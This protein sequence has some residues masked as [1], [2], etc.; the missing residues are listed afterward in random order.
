MSWKRVLSG[1]ALVAMLATGSAYGTTWMADFTNWSGVDAA[2]QSSYT[3]TSGANPDYFFCTTPQGSPAPGFLTQDS[4]TYVKFS[5]PAGGVAPRWRF[6]NTL[7][8]SMK[9]TNGFGVAW[10]MNLFDDRNFNRGPVQISFTADGTSAGTP[11]DAYFL[12]KSTLVGTDIQYTVQ[13]QANGGS[14]YSGINAYT[15]PV[16]NQ[17]LNGWH[18]WT[19]T[20]KVLAAE[21][22]PAGSGTMKQFA[23]FNLWLDGTPIFF[24]GGPNAT[25]GTQG[26]PVGPDGLTYSFRVASES[27]SPQYIG[28]GDLGYDNYQ[29]YAFDWVSFRDDNNGYFVPEPAALLLLAAG[30]G[31]MLG[32]RRR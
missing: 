15:L 30:G 1:T 23:Y 31:L 25:S 26:S 5:D 10:R 21:E 8:T 7:P 27:V 29:N 13:P 24:T 6:R 16:L 18:T 28:L 22:F 9:G 32:R 20:A 3:D 17:L 19:A 12:I 4:G 14:V 2:A 11:Y